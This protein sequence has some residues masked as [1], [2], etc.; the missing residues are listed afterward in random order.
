MSCWKC[1]LVGLLSALAILP[2][3]AGAA[4]AE[5][6]WRI[7]GANITGSKKVAVTSSGHT[8]IEAPQGKTLIVML[9]KEF[10]LNEF[11]LLASGASSGQI[12]ITKCEVT[13]EGKKNGCSA[14]VIS[15]KLIGK[16]FL[17]EKKSF[18][19]LQPEVSTKIF[20]VKFSGVCVL[21]EMVIAGSVVLEDFTLGENSL[22]TEL[23]EHQVRVASTKLFPSDLLRVG[24]T[25]PTVG[26]AGPTLGLSLTGADAGKKWSGLG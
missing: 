14:E 4:W 13:T 9:C 10:A 20:N 8:T 19:L 22:S 5:G 1:G 6:N 18:V 24:E 26:F 16:L 21:E 3:F 12:S 2:A 15:P 23:V 17:H 11:S 7:E 25:G